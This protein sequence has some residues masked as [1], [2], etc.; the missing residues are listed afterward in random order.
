MISFD[1]DDSVLLFMPDFWLGVVNLE[2]TKHLKK[3]KQRINAYS[4]QS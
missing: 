2:N 1:E 4:V 3:D